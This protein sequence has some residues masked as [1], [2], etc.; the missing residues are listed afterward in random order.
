MG[1]VRAMPDH[2]H[3][4]FAWDP[5]VIQARHSRYSAAMEAEMT[6][7]NR[8]K[9]AA[10]VRRSSSAADTLISLW[11][12]SRGLPEQPPK[13]WAKLGRKW[14]LC[15]LL[16]L[17]RLGLDADHVAPK[18]N[19]RKREAGLTEP[20]ALPVPDPV[21]SEEP[22]LPWVTR[23]QF[24]KFIYDLTMLR[25][26]DRVLLLALIS[27]QTEL[28]TRVTVAESRLDSLLHDEAQVTY[29]HQG[30]ITTG[31]PI[32][33]SPLH[34]IPSYLTGDLPGD[35]DPTLPKE[36]AE[37]V[38]GVP[39]AVK[40]EGAGGV[41]L[42]EEAGDPVLEKLNPAQRRALSLILKSYGALPYPSRF[43][44]LVRKCVAQARRLLH[45]VARCISE[46]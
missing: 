31:T 43:S 27:G 1:L 10:K 2:P 6:K 9:K 37:S 25:D 32:A 23:S 41:P 28:E 38:P 26:S 29:F 7:P 33:N 21:G 45:A 20:E 4:V 19:R 39:G 46:L 22:A 18:V 42:G 16:A 12:L 5:C 24:S 36:S 34:E 13:Q 40:G 30:G 44:R 35:T 15:D 11:R 17:I 3:H 14:K 8:S